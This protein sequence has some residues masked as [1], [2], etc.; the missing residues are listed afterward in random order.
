MTDTRTPP[1]SKTLK[2]FLED[3]PPGCEC[4]VIKAFTGRLH[5]THFELAIPEINLYCM[6]PECSGVRK[7][8]SESS[9]YTS[10][11][12]ETNDFLTYSCR[13]CG[14]SEKV[15][16]I[17]SRLEKNNEDV[18]VYKFGELPAFGPPTPP[19][20]M[21]ILGA[22]RD[23]Y[24][25]G[26][27]AENQGMGIAA[28]AYYRRVVEN[29]KEKIFSEIIRV[30]ERLNA[31]PELLRELNAAKHE[32]QFTK[33]VAVIKHGIPQ[34]LLI[35]G[36][37]PLTLLHTA[38]SEGLH[39]QTDEQCLELAMSIRVVLSDFVERVGNA[40]KDEKELKSAIGRLTNN[41]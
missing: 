36:H 27:R 1:N 13:N 4:L 15:Y 9:F 16:A 17:R 37:S 12:N 33:A 28:F 10:K 34:T 40:L 29:Q 5:S 11:L 32:K 39:A 30:A 23:Y 31:E 25:K 35:D 14:E 8:K 21:S 19:R 38:L 2:E 18:I 20:V 41:K 7:F 3:V 22:E 26:R 24:L 6:S